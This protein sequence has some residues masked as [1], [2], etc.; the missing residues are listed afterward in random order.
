MVYVYVLKSKACFTSALRQPCT[1]LRQQMSG[2]CAEASRCCKQHRKTALQKK[3]ARLPQG[4]N[5]NFQHVHFFC[6]FCA[7]SGGR[8]TRKASAGRLQDTQGVGTDVIFLH[9]AFCL[10]KA[11]RLPQDNRA[12]YCKTAA[13][14]LR[15]V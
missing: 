14:K 2:F 8:K 6:N 1:C 15:N 3:V 5:L 7:D 12:L 10:M 9:P 4:Q 11:A 13:R